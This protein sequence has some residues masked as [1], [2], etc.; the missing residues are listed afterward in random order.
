MEK[1]D[2]LVSAPHFFTMKGDGVGYCA[3]SAMA[4]DRGKI[5]AIGPREEILAHYRADR[6]IDAEGQAVLPGFIDA[7][8]AAGRDVLMDIDVQGAE[9]ILRRY[10]D[11]VTVF[12][13]APSM[14][15]LRRRLTARGLDDSAVIDNV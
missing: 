11:A 14:D 2:L 9:Q 3:N 10:P 13:K 4:V 12:I 6:T 7:H 1:I 5:L 8:M 15:E